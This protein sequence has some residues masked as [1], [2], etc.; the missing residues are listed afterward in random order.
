MRR[1]PRYLLAWAGACVALFVAVLAVAYFLPGPRHVDKAAVSDFESLDARPV[2][3]AVA[4]VFGSLCD[5]IEYTVIVAGF[6]WL[7]W[8]KRG[9]RIAATAGLLLIGANVS[10]QVLKV[11][12]AYPR[13]HPLAA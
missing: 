9:P 10:S 5:W 12:L 7:V 8:R 2:I 3:H 11:L 13:D 1:S 4:T 6:L